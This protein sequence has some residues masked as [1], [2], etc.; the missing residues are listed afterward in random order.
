M[1]GKMKN[2]IT[3]LR[4]EC[5][6]LVY[7]PSTVNFFQL[8]MLMELIFFHTPHWHFKIFFEILNCAIVVPLFDF[9]CSAWIL[10]SQ[11][12]GLAF[13]FVYPS[14]RVTRKFEKQTPLF[15]EEDNVNMVDLSQMLLPKWES[16][17]HS[18][19]IGVTSPA[20][21]DSFSPFSEKF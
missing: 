6:L 4:L 17:T 2:I 16:A 3:D 11:I 1:W 14:Q 10:A 19:T 20:Q 8:E 18:I 13:L 9:I 12:L 7:L 15:G 5:T 21:K